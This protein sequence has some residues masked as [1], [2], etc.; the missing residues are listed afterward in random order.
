MH[1]VRHDDPR[2]MA[3]FFTLKTHQA[4]SEVIARLR[5]PQQA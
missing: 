5:F 1:V 2:M 3:D 4:F